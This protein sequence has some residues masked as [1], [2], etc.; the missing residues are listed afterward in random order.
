MGWAVMRATWGTRI[1]RTGCSKLPRPLVRSQCSEMAR[2]K[3]LAATCG[4]APR[5]WSAA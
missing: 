4:V 1:K 5:K 3:W 2:A